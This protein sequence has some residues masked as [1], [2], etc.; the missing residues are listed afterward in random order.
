M[1]RS[2]LELFKFRMCAQLAGRQQT[3]QLRIDA[4]DLETNLG[5]QQGD[6]GF[7]FFTLGVGTL[8]MP[9]LSDAW[10]LLTNV[11]FLIGVAA[12]VVAQTSDSLRNPFEEPFTSFYA[13]WLVPAQVIGFHIAVYCVVLRPF[14]FFA[15]LCQCHV[16]VTQRVL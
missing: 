16:S 4:V 7:H 14:A 8:A 13:T 9:V 11:E 10:N 12:L 1:T 5:G 6:P 15:K 3:P 2:E